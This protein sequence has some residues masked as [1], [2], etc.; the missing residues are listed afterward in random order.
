[1]RLKLLF[2]LFLFT[3]IT[4]LGQDKKFFFGFNIGAKFGNKNYALRYTGWYQNELPLVLSN[5]IVHQKLYELLGNQ[6][7]EFFEFNTDY[8]Y[9]PAVN[10]GLNVGYAI[11]PNFQATIDVNFSQPEVRTNYSVKLF[12][13]GNQTTQEQY[14]VGNVFGKEGRFNGKFNLDY[15][16]DV[17]K[18]KLI[19]GVQGLF[20]AWRMEELV[21]E[22]AN[23]QWIH[24]AYT[25]H[26]VTNNVTKK[27]SGSGWGYGVNLGIEYRLNKK[28]VAQL[29]YQPYFS[30]LE[31]FNTK[32]Q[33]A[34][35]SDYSGLV[36]RLE[37]D[38]TLRIQWK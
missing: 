17:G 2:V 21:F 37:H 33:I 28:I 4:L 10:Y 16:F 25:V 27:T 36:N 1:M 14:R 18:I 35:S 15:L 29:M 20:L 3:N 13:P 31:Y 26:A 24:S 12:D 7:F 11:N 34:T 5:Q 6:D 9:T 19:A 32:S 30:R 8:G 38:V 22:L 23:E